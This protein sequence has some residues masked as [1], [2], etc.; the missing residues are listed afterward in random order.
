MTEEEELRKQVAELQ[1]KTVELAERLKALEPDPEFKRQPMP[2]WDPTARMRMPASAIQAMVEA[3]P[4]ALVRNIARDFHRGV[5]APSSMIPGRGQEPVV[6]GSGWVDPAP[7]ASPP[8]IKLIDQMA[9]V[10]DRQWRAE[11]ARQ[12]GVEPK[13]SVSAIKR[14]V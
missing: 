14:R 5:T 7:L 6:R 13:P 8:G 1:A 11:R 10:E 12:F 2:R 3:V 9:A 4:D